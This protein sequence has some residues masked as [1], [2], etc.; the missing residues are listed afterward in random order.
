M[1]AAI[2]DRGKVHP[3]DAIPVARTALVVIDMQNYFVAPNAQGEAETARDIVPAINR[4][5]AALRERG[6]RVIWMQNTT[7][8]T[9]EKW[10]VRHELLPPEKAETRLAAMELGAEGYQLWPT[11]D[12]RADDTRIGEEGLFGFHPGLLRPCHASQGAWNR[13]RSR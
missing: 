10:S 2:A 3:W 13:I 7:T 6:G 12:V 9:R 4:L 5:A 8:D 1:A 11:L